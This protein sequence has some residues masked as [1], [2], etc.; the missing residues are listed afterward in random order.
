MKP[1]SLFPALSADVRPEGRAAL[2]PWKEAKMLKIQICLM[3]SSVQPLTVCPQIYC[4]MIC[5]TGKKKRK[6]GRKKEGREEVSFL[7]IHENSLYQ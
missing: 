1:F 3:T 6:E 2:L 5:K 4:H 7:K